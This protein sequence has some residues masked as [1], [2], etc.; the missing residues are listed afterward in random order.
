MVNTITETNEKK[1][2]VPTLVNP[3]ISVDK[4]VE[5]KEEKKIE[6]VS[7]DKKIE[8]DFSQTSQ[9]R[10]L[11]ICI[12]SRGA[13]PTIWMKHMVD[14]VCK[15]IPSG[16]YWNF[17]WAIGTPDTTGENYADLR[18]KCIKEALMR[19]S[20]WV[21]FIDDDVFVPDR[22]IQR[23]LF[24]TQQG[25]KVISGIY[26]KKC[27]NVEPVIFKEL[28]NGPYFNF[29][30][31]SVFEIEGSGAGCLFIDLE[32]FK[33]FD[34]A[35][36]PY[37]KQDWIMDLNDGKETTSEKKNLVQVEIGEDHWLFYQAKR[38]GFQ[39]YCDSTLMCDHYDTKTNKMFPIESEV[40]RVRGQDFRDKSEYKERLDLLKDAKKPN[41]VFICPSSLQFSGKSLDEKPLGGSETAL[42]H[43]ARGLTKEN[44]VVVFSSCQEPGIYEDVLYLDISL[45][46]IMNGLPIDTLVLY[47]GNAPQYVEELKKKFNPKRYFFWT[48]DYPMYQGFD[49]NFP[50]VAKSFDKLI[51]VSNDHRKALLDRFPLQ[52]EEDK[53]I[54]I[55]NGVDN[56]LFL[57]KDKIVK[58]KNQFYYSSTPYRGLEILVDLFPKIKEKVPDAT[59]KV[60]SSMHVYGDQMGDKAYENL[61]KKCKATDG[62]EYLG[63]LKQK[64]LAKVAMESELMLYSCVFAET[65]CISVEES[66]TAGTPVICNDLAALKETVHNG[67]GIKIS[68]NP[69]TKEWQEQFV[70]T[71]IKVCS[72]NSIWSA[73]H[74][75]CLKQNFDWSLSVD[76]WKEILK[77]PIGEQSI[78]VEKP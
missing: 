25:M 77:Q 72:D 70:Q 46:D 3:T 68:G 26:Y 39:P 8:A 59:L 20:K 50:I 31:N 75:E 13:I 11:S 48:Q 22:T 12:I 66:Q 1:E 57:E 76:K 65:N 15:F 64:E 53:V 55:E 69:K 27:D 18:N 49:Q 29:P 32:I 38:L 47:R 58:K 56:S 60:C 33:K 71:V 2:D 10:G 74:T 7:D 4:I 40:A 5:K 41:L 51:C 14:K 78:P 19:G 45:L 63:S 24:D 34:E 73:M 52:L 36:I 30:T 23:M 35:K 17:I 61:Y 62:I 42:I 54:V 28:G 44:N 6:R 37:F 9:R 43:T 67:C 21:L 16:I